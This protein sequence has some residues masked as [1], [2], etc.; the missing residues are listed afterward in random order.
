MQRSSS[1][2][3]LNGVY[4]SKNTE[5]GNSVKHNHL[6]TPNS[7]PNHRPKKASDNKTESM[8][9]WLMKRLVVR[10]PVNTGYSCNGRPETT[11]MPRCQLTT[12][13]SSENYSMTG[14]YVPED[15]ASFA[16]SLDE[17]TYHFN[18]HAIRS[19]YMD[20]SIEAKKKVSKYHLSS[21]F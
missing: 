18:R 7:Q 14:T 8:K 5:L 4:D 15:A 11:L 13:S 3:A 20:K 21:F 19:N 2:P 6:V 12:P 9:M 16:T 1:S 17:T 10:L